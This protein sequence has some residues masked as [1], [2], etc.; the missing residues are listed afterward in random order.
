MRVLPQQIPANESAGTAAIR[1]R[2]HRGFREQLHFYGSNAIRNL[3]LMRGLTHFTSVLV[4]KKLYPLFNQYLL[5]RSRFQP[6]P[7]G[8]L[9][10]ARY[11]VFEQIP[12]AD[13]ETLYQESTYLTFSWLEQIL[14]QQGACW[15]GYEKGR[16]AAYCCTRAGQ[17]HA[18]AP[19]TQDAYLFAVEVLAAF[20]GK[21]VA[22]P[23]LQEVCHALFASG[24]EN[25]WSETHLFN[26]P[27]NRMHR[28]LGFEFQRKIRVPIG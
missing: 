21:K 26:T 3:G 13:L 15:L 19:G 28:R 12:P 14:R 16:L 11:E 1:R 4:E 22:V 20:R 24:V 23:F 5:S 27:S 7:D 6:P 2:I 17:P 10:V 9:R 25:L 8:V 18:T